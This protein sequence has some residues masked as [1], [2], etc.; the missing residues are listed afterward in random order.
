MNEEIEKLK[1]EGFQ[2]FEKKQFKSAA[3]IFLACVEQ[4]E[5]EGQNPDSAEMRNNLGVALVRNK[6]YQAAIEA[7][8]GTDKTFAQAGDLQKQ[9]M[10][11]A[12]LG[13]AYEGLKNFEA[14]MQAYEGAVECF[15][16]CGEQK[17]LSVVL[18]YLSDLQMKTGKQY[19]ALASLKSSYEE[20]P[21]ANLKNN[22]FKRSIDMMIKKVTGR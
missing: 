16:Q 19:Q 22:F 11:L 12:N 14:A 20:A 15:K 4:L 10:A 21:N 17:M 13:N 6:Q 8:I 18:K 2:K 7:L 5:G 3:E 1:Q 9:G